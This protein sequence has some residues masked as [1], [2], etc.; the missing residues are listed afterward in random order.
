MTTA[1]VKPTPPTS[2]RVLRIHILRLILVMVA[3]LDVAAHMFASPGATPLISY[4]IDIETASYSLIAVIYLLGLRIYYL[5]PILFTLY[6]MG[7]FFLSGVVA[8]PWGISH[9]PLVG[10]VQF[11]QYSFGRGMS[12]FAWI[13]LLGL[14]V[15]MMKLDSGSRLNDLLRDS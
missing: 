2:G 3:L 12:L 6:N 11:L 1:H 7:M 8:L 4:W 10:H 15:V 9:A 13:V 14:G 5:P